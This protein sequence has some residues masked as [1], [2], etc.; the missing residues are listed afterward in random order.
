MNKNY[1]QPWTFKDTLWQMGE[2]VSMAVEMVMALLFTLVV[3]VLPACIVLGA[4]VLLFWELSK[5]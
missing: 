5:P 4:I 1:Y 2:W 3:F